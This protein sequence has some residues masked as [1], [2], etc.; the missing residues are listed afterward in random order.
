M[1]DVGAVR[2]RGLD[3]DRAHPLSSKVAS[4]IKAA[5]RMGGVLACCAECVMEA[6]VA[7]REGEGNREY[8]VCAVNEC[9]D[10]CIDMQR[11]AG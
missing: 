1:D 8:A 6:A 2:Q 10:W 4:G 7:V 11:Y 3:T 9:I 5:G